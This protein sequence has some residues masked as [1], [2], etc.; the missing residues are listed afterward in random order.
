LYPKKLAVFFPS[1]FVDH[2]QKFIFVIDG[3]SGTL[4]PYAE[5]SELRPGRTTRL[6]TTKP[7]VQFS[8]GNFL[9]GVIGTA[10]SVY[11]KH[12]GFCLETQRFPDSPNTEQNS[13]QA[14]FG[15]DRDYHEKAAFSFL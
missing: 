2:H 15:P 13:P 7:G 1:Y 6:F 12:S 10:G 3:D 11:G 5:V 14:I 4:R 9:D 8:T